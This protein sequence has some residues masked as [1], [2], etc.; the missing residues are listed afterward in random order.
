M[1]IL[2]FVSEEQLNEILSKEIPNLKTSDKPVN[3]V[4]PNQKVLGI[5]AQSIAYL[6]KKYP[7]KVVKTI[8]VTGTADQ[9][10]QFLRLCTKHQNNPYFPKIYAM[11]YYPSKQEPNNKLDFRDE[12]FE[13]Y[14]DDYPPARLDNT[15]II[16]TEFLTPLTDITN[17]DIHRLGLDDFELP[18]NMISYKGRNDITFSMAFKNPTWRKY[19]QVHATDPQLKQAL[20]LLEPL[21]K[22][23]EP[24]MHT[25]NVMIRPPNQ[26]VFIDPISANYDDDDENL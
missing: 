8:Q 12:D 22:H 18:N 15:L 7:D 26:W 5:G 13:D 14:Y 17:D 25:N 10:Y 24:D 1:K 21:F 4:W 9:S 2:E 19:M 11:K 16:V 6:H 23:Y 20:R 3:D